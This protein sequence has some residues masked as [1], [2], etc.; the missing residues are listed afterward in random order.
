MKT[1]ILALLLGLSLIFSARDVQAAGTFVAVSTEIG[2]TNTETLA[3]GTTWTSFDNGTGYQLGF[4]AY[5]G[6]G[7]WCAVGAGVS[8]VSYYSTNNGAT[9][10]SG[11]SVGQGSRVLAYGA[12]VFTVARGSPGFNA[13]SSDCI[14]WTPH[15]GYPIGTNPSQE[16]WDSA[17]ST[18]IGVAGTS[19]S[20]T[21]P[22]G[23]VW[24]SNFNVFPLTSMKWIASCAGTT[25]TI[26]PSST[27]A[28][29]STN[30]VSWSAITLADAAAWT[31]IACSDASHFTAIG[32]D[33]TTDYTSNGG[34]SWSTGSGLST[35]APTSIAW[36]G[37]EYVAVAPSTTAFGHS[38]DGHAWTVESSGAASLAAPALA[39]STTAPA[40]AASGAGNLTLIGVGQ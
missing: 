18:F 15:S 19:S 6:S 7:L 20:L 25:I 31:G 10:T 4:V 21:S 9:W 29:V 36:N 26:Q 13:T 3:S 12:G 28:F 23:A 1:P 8:S 2:S 24:T 5:N 37:A 17:H 30:G 35:L 38:A 39:A 32:S 27:S 16:I 33:G 40:P 22:D 11:G 34:T 14:T